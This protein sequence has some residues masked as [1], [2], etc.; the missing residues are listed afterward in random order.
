[1]D[2]K[3]GVAEFEIG[4]FFEAIKIQFEGHPNEAIVTRL[5]RRDSHCFERW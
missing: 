5:S 3:M 2:D 4:P 1:M